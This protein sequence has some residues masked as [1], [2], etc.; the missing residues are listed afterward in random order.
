VKTQFRESANFLLLV[1]SVPALRT[2]SSISLA[3]LVYLGNLGIA[4]HINAPTEYA[5]KRE[6]AMDGQM[7][8]RGARP[9]PRRILVGLI[10][11]GDDDDDS[12][13]R[14]TLQ[15]ERIALISRA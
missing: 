3:F 8:G 7:D 6:S 1:S 12:S 13:S 5:V 14:C 10:T 15:R 2:L 11:A 4:S 9:H